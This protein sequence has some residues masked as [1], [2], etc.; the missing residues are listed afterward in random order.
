MKLNKYFLLFLLP[1]CSFA[2]E[3]GKASYYGK[4][5]ENKLMANGEL[6]NSNNL[7]CASWD[8]KLGTYLK[9]TNIANN[10]FV[11]VKVTDR[12]PNKRLHRIIDLS[13]TSFNIIGNINQGLIKV[14]IEVIK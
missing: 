10:K 11:V 9:V 3:I 4:E 8:Y 6:F 2:Q 12:G 14:K 7:T 5:C 13:R 1:I